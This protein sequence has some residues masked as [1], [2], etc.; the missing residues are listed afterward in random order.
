[1]VSVDTYTIQARYF[2]A[3][4][5][6][7]PT[8]ALLL[9]IFDWTEFQPG[10]VLALGGLGFLVFALGDYARRKGKNIE[11][12]VFDA[13]GGKPTVIMLRHSDN[14]FDAATKKRFIEFLQKKTGQ[15][16]PSIAA[17]NADLAA[18]DRAYDSYGA[19]LRENTRDRSRFQILSKENIT[20]GFRR[21]LLGLK[22]VALSLNLFVVAI[23][24][25]TYVIIPEIATS[26]KL[27]FILIVAALHA[28]YFLVVVSRDSVIEAANVYAR[29][30]ILSCEQ[31]IN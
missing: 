24:L 4:L 31:I 19:W 13:R 7:L 18:S 28:L 22:L 20:Y 15:R 8:I 10:H 5:A 6:V 23:S 17:E 25:F 27:V 2:P 29:Q 3:A 21:N 16:A 11:Q 30:L 12:D 9:M 14:T 1:M 26:K